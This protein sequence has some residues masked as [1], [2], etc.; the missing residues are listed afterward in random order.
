MPTAAAH[1]GTT[2]LG[3]GSKLQL[4]PHMPLLCC[5]VLLPLINPAGLEADGSLASHPLSINRPIRKLS[6]VD[7]WFDSVSYNKGAAVLR[8]LRA[9]VNRADSTAT[10]LQAVPDAPSAAS[11]EYNAKF[12]STSQ[13]WVPHLRRL[14]QQQQTSEGSRR[15]K[16]GV[17]SSGSDDSSSSSNGAGGSSQPAPHPSWTAHKYSKGPSIQ[18]SISP[19]LHTESGELSG[20]EVLPA[21]AAA[22]PTPKPAAAAAAAKR[23]PS[24]ATAISVGSRAGWLAAQQQQPAREL[25]DGGAGSAGGGDTFV[26][27]LSRYVKAHAYGNSGYRGLW[28]SIG[29]AA[30]EPVEQMMSTWTLRRCVWAGSGG[31]GEVLSLHTLARGGGGFA[32]A[33]S[34]HVACRAAALLFLLLTVLLQRSRDLTAPLRVD[35]C[36]NKRCWLG[37]RSMCVC[38]FALPQYPAGASRSSLC[39]WAPRILAAAGVRSS[40]IRF[41][42]TPPAPTW[43][44]CPLSQRCTAMTGELWRGGGGAQERLGAEACMPDWLA[45]GTLTGRLSRSW[46]AHGLCTL[47]GCGAGRCQFEARVGFGVTAATL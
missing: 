41:P 9:W 26:A 29:E 47:C 15:R 43:W 6:E 1:A 27:G 13:E 19:L 24:A 5:A 22:P 16:G 20:L 8:M 10:G 46:A 4:Q 25:P 34:L 31:R 17:T 44:G 40:W 3:K 36:V 28:D 7:N 39:H 23:Q 2:V 38:F 30:G 14:Q 42:T 37:A 12:A 18:A 11:S 45:G 33:R 21:G 32:H 35:M